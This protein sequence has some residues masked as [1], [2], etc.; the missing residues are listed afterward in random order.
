MR[1][2]SLSTDYFRLP[3]PP[4]EDGGH[5]AIDTEELVFVNVHTDL[6]DGFGYAY[7]IG[8]GGRAIRSLI[9][10]EIADAVIGLDFAS[11]E[12][13][14][15]HVWRR[16]LYIGRGGL[17]SFAIAAL[18]MALWDAYAKADGVPLYR[19]IGAQ[20]KELPT[21]GSGVDLQKST[22][23]LLEQIDGYKARGLRGVK[24]KVGRPTL[25]EDIERVAAVRDHLGTAVDLMVDANMA[26]DRD[27]AL[28]AARQLEPFELRWL[29]E[30]LTPEDIE[31]HAHLRRET[32]TPLSVGESF[33]SPAEF[34]A[35]ARAGG[36]DVFQVDPVTNGGVT[37]AIEALRA[38]NAAGIDASSHYADE[39]NAHIL[40]LAERPVFLEKHAFALDA[41][42]EDPQEIVD[43]FV[44]PSERPGHGIAFLAEAVEPFRAD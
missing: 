28:E 37:V 18:D 21:Y 26:W 13:A 16:M 4:S 10:H 24:M 7:T 43:G 41:Y 44:R 42:L 20:S 22:E 8:K 34:H 17:T 23:D 39:L 15:R 40:C 25:S 33:H 31:G 6:A 12:D 9:D 11:P 14:W 1:I 30:P 3:L 5:G 19:A 2:M 36:S 35:Y 27:E 38:A 29:E 32:S